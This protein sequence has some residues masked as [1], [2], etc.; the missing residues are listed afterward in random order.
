MRR[1]NPQILMVVFVV[2]GA[3]AFLARLP[4]P[5]PAEAARLAPRFQFAWQ[6]LPAAP[7]PPGGVVH[8]VNKRT[9]HLHFYL[10]Q[11][12]ASAALGDLDGDGLPNDLCLTDIRAK[13][14]TVSPV[15]G[16]GNRYPS[17]TLDAWDRVDRRTEHPSVCRVADMNEDGL[18]DLFV[19]FWGRAP[20]LLVR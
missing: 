19:A 7:M 14:L 6:S 17:F 9:Q 11:L 3:L 2:V 18:A 13:T 5:S 15:P 20:L 1:Q 8:E 4:S 10:Y 12:G 16:T